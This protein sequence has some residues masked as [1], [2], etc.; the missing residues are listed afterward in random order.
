MEHFTKKRAEANPLCSFRYPNR[1]FSHVCHRF[2]ALLLYNPAALCMLMLKTAR[3]PQAFKD[4]KQI[5]PYTFRPFAVPFKNQRE[6]HS[7]QKLQ[8]F[9]TFQIS[10][11]ILPPFFRTFSIFFP[12]LFPYSGPSPCLI[13]PYFFHP[14]SILFPY[15]CHPD[16]ARMIRCQPDIQLRFLP[17]CQYGKTDFCCRQI[18]SYSPIVCQPVSNLTSSL[19]H[20]ISKETWISPA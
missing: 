18:D 9:D 6:N 15:Y 13:F 11:A 3:K 19:E 10:A 7:I 8:I 14:F 5:I 12:P 16:F 2:A 4:R 17:S 20:R 1:L